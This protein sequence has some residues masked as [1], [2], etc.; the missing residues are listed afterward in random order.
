[1]LSWVYTYVYKK[2]LTCEN[3]FDVMGLGRGVDSVFLKFANR[4]QD[5]QV[6]GN[7][8]GVREGANQSNSAY[9]LGY[10]SQ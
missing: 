10:T 4:F 2:A 7:A 6:S 9:N 5:Y 1:M 8:A 3:F